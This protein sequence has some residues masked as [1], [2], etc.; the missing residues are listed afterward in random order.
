[1]GREKHINKNREEIDK[2]LSFG[3]I[4]FNV[5]RLVATNKRL[6]DENP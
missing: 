5:S 6:L 4:Y 1:M 3:L 2:L